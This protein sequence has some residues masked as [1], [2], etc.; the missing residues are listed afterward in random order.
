MTDATQ[1]RSGAG[2]GASVPRFV[3]V[4]SGYPPAVRAGLERG[5]ERLAHALAR[6]G[7]PV[8]VL[9]LAVDGLAA[10]QRDASG[11][12][13]LRVLRPFGPGAAWGVTYL[14]ATAR[15]LWRLR[16][17]WDVVFCQQLYLHSVAATFA[18]R[19]LGK[20]SASLLVAGDSYS[21]IGRL[22]AL[23]G[24]HWL[25][26]QAL[27]GD[28][29]FAL[30]MRSAAEL[31]TAGVPP[32]RVFPYRYFVDMDTFSPG[33][34][35]Q[36]RDGAFLFLG[37]FDAQK[38]LGLLIEA[39]ERVHARAPHARLRLIGRGPQEAI[40]R[41]RVA[42]SRSAANI[43]IEPWT[44]DPAAA[45][46]RA[47]AVV[48]ASDAEGLSNVLI[49]AMACGRPVITTDV[50]GARD[51]LDGVD[52]PEPLPP[53]TAARGS[54]GLLV[55]RGDAEGLAAAM[56]DVLSRP[57]LQQVLGAEARARAVA[58]Y[59]EEVCLDEFLDNVGRLMG[60]AESRR[61]WRV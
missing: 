52:W 6:R 51:A 50:S 7:Y 41:A 58:I 49:E 31:R 40:L 27:A 45:Y 37:R 13:V 39:F 35:G 24:G 15:W 34:D 38:N 59:S 8:A 1:L 12:E 21:D 19:A 56:L 4:S 9:T 16:H 57:E 28:A 5:C 3:L 20:I 46:R 55:N 2:V 22:A 17:R 11:A 25:V 33:T 43:V 42:A 14:L 36:G 30:S 60:V 44:D 54:G 26:R 10:R 29:L 61:T 48:T 23:R 32:S 18:A 47:L 53:G